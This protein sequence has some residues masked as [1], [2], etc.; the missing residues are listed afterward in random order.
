MADRIFVYVDGESHYI[1]SE[2]AWRKLRDSGATLAR[3][4]Y[5]G[6]SDDGLILVDP[7]AKLFWTKKMHPEARRTY[8][9]TSVSGDDD[10]LHR[11][12]ALLRSFGLEPMV[13]KEQRQLARQRHNLLDTDRL[14][15]KPK[16][17][18][19]E[20]AVMM[21]EDAHRNAFDL[22]HLYTSD[23]D[24]LPVVKAVRAQYKQVIVH[25]YKDG[26]SK[27]SPFHHAC[28]LFIDLE[29]VLDDQC[30]LAP[31]ARAPELQV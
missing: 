25:G 27:Q 28:D 21:L 24:F 30:E 1:R 20:L 12:M 6:D 11:A 9:F 23:I 16:G 17:V 4:R 5:K 18:D 31:E 10:A 14:I 26:L 22:C 7:N 29:C 15:E 19:I 2:N 13:L 8:Y 3:L